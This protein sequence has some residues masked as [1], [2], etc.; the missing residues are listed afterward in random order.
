M[1]KI[2]Y[3]CIPTFGPP[4]MLIMLIFIDALTRTFVNQKR[5]ALFLNKTLKTKITK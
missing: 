2:V 4:C 1:K 5:L 3:N